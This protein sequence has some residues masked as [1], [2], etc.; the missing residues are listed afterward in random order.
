MKT[1]ISGV[2]KVIPSLAIFQQFN[3]TKMIFIEDLPCASTALNLK[4]QRNISQ[5]QPSVE[6]TYLKAFLGQYLRYCQCMCK[7]LGE[8]Q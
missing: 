3:S 5:S 2:P 6:K 8:E 4:K 7:E 1:P